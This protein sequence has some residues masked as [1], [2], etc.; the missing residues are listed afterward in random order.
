MCLIIAPKEPTG[1]LV[2]DADKLR[3]AFTQN[4]DGWGFMWLDE[5]DGAPS[6]GRMRGL[7]VDEL[8][9]A[10]DTLKDKPGLHLH[11]RTKTHGLVDVKN[12]HPFAVTTDT[13]LMHNGILRVDTLLPD[14]S[15]TWHYAALISRRFAE[16]GDTN[17]IYFDEKWQEDTAKFFGTSRGVFLREDGKRWICN[18]KYGTWYEDQWYSNT[19]G[20]PWIKPKYDYSH[21]SYPM[22]GY[23]MS[24]SIYEDYGDGLGYVRQPISG[25]HSDRG[26]L[27]Q[28]GLA[29]GWRKQDRWPG[30]QLCNDGDG[31][32]SC[33]SCGSFVCGDCRTYWKGFGHLCDRC[34]S[35]HAG[36]TQP[37]VEEKEGV[38]DE[39]GTGV[40]HGAVGQEEQC[41]QECGGQGSVG[42]E[43][44]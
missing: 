6:L 39:T 19:G 27:R 23:Y 24:D 32:V 29:A 8:V 36:G 41:V 20:A 35:E 25:K 3:S 4:D 22:H 26:S 28:P 31:T 10:Y 2:L 33:K 7:L 40:G 44:K 13:L 12:C 18:E 42:G 1:K 43:E 15:D 14:R 37:I 30:C 16:H 17:P 11:L 21:Q 5:K 34:L 38:K 9:A